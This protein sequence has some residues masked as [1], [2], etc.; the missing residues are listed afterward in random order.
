MLYG[1]TK[2]QMKVFSPGV[3][4]KDS[5]CVTFR[6]EN[7]SILVFWPYQEKKQYLDDR[8]RG[9][10]RRQE[11]KR[12]AAEQLDDGHQGVDLPAS[13]RLHQPSCRPRPVVS[14]HVNRRRGDDTPRY[15]IPDI[16]LVLISLLFY[17]FSSLRRGD[18]STVFCI[19]SYCYV[20]L[21]LFYL[22]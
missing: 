6:K 3:R 21:L 8:I 20:I 9:K 1:K 13:L 12:A 7:S 14:L 16:V 19:V 15:Q 17:S 18:Q 10:V 2:L 5:S 4:Q 11:T 22:W